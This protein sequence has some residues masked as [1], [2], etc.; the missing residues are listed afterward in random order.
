MRLLLFMTL[1][2]TAALGTTRGD[3]EERITIT[4]EFLT[5]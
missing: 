3:R 2:V 5:S 4:F 1:K